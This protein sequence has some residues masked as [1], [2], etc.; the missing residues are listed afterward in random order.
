MTPG[1]LPI[2]R[3]GRAT[4]ADVAALAGVSRAAVSKVFN[5]TGHISVATTTRIQETAKKLDWTP[6]TAAVALRRSRS[7]A[8]GLVLNRPAEFEIGTSWWMRISGLESV[9]APKGYGLLLYLIDR[10]PDHEAAVYRTLAQERRVDAVILTDSRFGDGRFALMRSLGLPAVL[11]GTPAGGDSVPYVDTDPAG[12]GVEDAIDHLLAFG[13]T[14]IGYIGGPDDRVQA[15][16]RRVMFEECM[17]KAGLRPAACISADYNPETAAKRTAELLDGS[18]AQP[19]AII[20]GSDPMAIAGMK[21]ARS[22]G[23]VVPRDISIV[24][25]DGLPAGAWLEPSLTTVQRDAE[26]RGRAVATKILEILGE[27]VEEKHDIGAPYLVIRDS[28]GLAPA[29]D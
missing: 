18:P 8:V 13:H 16:A 1:D 23:L 11:I 6:N 14:K 24:G 2:R 26:Q 25:F 4:I 9:L 5:G 12:A 19:T 17:A 7:K 22:K 20:Y 29:N 3:S 10:N 15:R 21:V 27:T 28:T